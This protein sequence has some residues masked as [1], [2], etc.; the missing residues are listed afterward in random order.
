MAKKRKK[1]V[2]CGTIREPKEFGSNS[3]TWDGLQ[4]YCKSCKN[5]L[6]K[7]RRELNVNARLKHHMATRVSTQLGIYAPPS[8]TLKLEGLLGYKISALVK[9]LSTELR[10]R[11]DK[12][13]RKALQEGYHVDHIKPL[14]LFPVIKNGKIDIE[15]F[16]DCWRIKN[17]KAISAHENLTKGASYSQP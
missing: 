12:S 13:L 7:K 3:G 17:L 6:G 9:Y 15:V 14:S 11:E 10:E 16:Q 8:V 5:D 2:K 1:C 4:T